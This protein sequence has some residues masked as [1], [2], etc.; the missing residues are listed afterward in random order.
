MLDHFFV[1]PSNPIA[2][3][4]RRAISVG[5]QVLPSSVR[6]SVLRSVL[7]GNAGSNWAEYY[8]HATTID[9]SQRKYQLLTAVLHRECGRVQ[10]IGCCSGREVAYFAQ[11]FP[12]LTFIGSDLSERVV[13]MCRATYDLPNLSFRSVDAVQ[14]D[15]G[16]DLVVAL[17]VLVYM[18]AEEIRQ[19]AARRPRLFAAE[20]VRTGYDGTRTAYWGRMAWNHPYRQLFPSAAYEEYAAPGGGRAVVLSPVSL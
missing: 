20:P 11:R 19:F 8:Q 7:N 4:T 12:S 9:F 13:A 14:A 17:G 10:W 5:F 15:F 3:W 16:P 2:K 18:D 1:P 6:R